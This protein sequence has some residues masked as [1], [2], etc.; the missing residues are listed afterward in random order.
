MPD[1]GWR[2]TKREFFENCKSKKGAKGL[3]SG[4]C[5][6][7]VDARKRCGMGGNG[8]V[9]ENE[10][11]G[12]GLQGGDETTCREE[13]VNRVGGDLANEDAGELGKLRRRD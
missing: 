12:R 9:A 11:G 10:P 5:E 3:K 4:C 6:H 2:G 1:D 13:E 7:C 8:F